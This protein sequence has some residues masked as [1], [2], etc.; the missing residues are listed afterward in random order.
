MRILIYSENDVAQAA[1]ERLKG[2]GHQVS[3]RNP[4]FFNPLQFERCDKA[5]AY[6]PQILRAYQAANIPAESLDVAHAQGPDS[7]RAVVVASREQRAE[8]EEQ[9]DAETT[10]PADFPGLRAL[11]EAGIQTYEQVRAIEDL[12][13]I[14]G[15]GN[16]TADAILA[17]LEEEG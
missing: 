15:I 5:L 6:A 4:Q 2:E 8:K 1:R 3:L 13:S 7:H 17:H 16:A 11:H 10:L 9:A 14:K 12:T